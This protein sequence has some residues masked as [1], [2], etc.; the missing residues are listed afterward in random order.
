MGCPPQPATRRPANAPLS[1]GC[2]L[3]LQQV[4][5]KYE[6][7]VGW[8]GAGDAIAPIAEVRTDANAALTADPH[9][10]DAVFEAGHDLSRTQTKPADPLF[11]NAFAPIER[12]VI[13]DFDRAALLGA[14]PVAEPDVLKLDTPAAALHRWAAAGRPSTASWFAD[15]GKP[16]SFGAQESPTDDDCAVPW[17]SAA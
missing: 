14:G 5:A 2:R 15:R 12:Q 6:D 8:Y 17:L 7:C 3:D 13:A 9:A 11:L 4:D 1:I 10:F 16:A